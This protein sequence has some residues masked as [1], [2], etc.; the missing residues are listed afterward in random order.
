MAL[1]SVIQGILD[2]G[3]KEAEKTIAEGRKERDDNLSRTRK[4][5]EK[6]IAAKKVEAEKQAE[7][8]KTQ[9]TA[10]A[11]IESKKVVLKAQKESLD[12]IYS[13]TLQRLSE[14]WSGK[15]IEEIFRQKSGELKNCSVYSNKADRQT[16]ERMASSHG[17]KFGGEI[18]CHGG[19]IIENEDKTVRTDYLLETILQTIW[20]DSAIEVTSLLWEDKPNER[21]GPAD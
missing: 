9:E 18:D 19:I 15:L 16:V 2:E 10:R 5:G 21:V 4:E 6:I 1:E 7:R 20:D 3:K 14:R 11:E 8:I 12:E 13:L 17:C